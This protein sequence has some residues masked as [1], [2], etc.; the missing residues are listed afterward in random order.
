MRLEVRPY[1]HELYRHLAACDL[2]VVQG[3]LTTAMELTVSRR[4][5][6]YFPLGHHFEQKVHVRHR[7]DRYRVGPVH[8]LH[9]GR[10]RGDCR[11]DRVRNRTRSRLPSG[12]QRRRRPS[13]GSARRSLV[14]PPDRSTPGDQGA[15]GGSGPPIGSSGRHT[16]A[17]ITSSGIVARA[18]RCGRRT[19]QASWRTGSCVTQGGQPQAK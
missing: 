4:P 11:R 7:L 16:V 18:R 17:I 5:F 6:L 19:G 1:V 15:V 3:G 13:G 8:G 10:A 14:T 12:R 2:A 9:D